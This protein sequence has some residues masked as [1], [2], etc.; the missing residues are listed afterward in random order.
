[1]LDVFIKIYRFGKVVHI[2]VDTN[3]D[4]AAFTRAFKHLFVHTLL[5]RNDGRKHH[6]AGALGQFTH[7]RND[8]VDRLLLY[9]LAAYRTVRNTDTGIEQAEIIVNLGRGAHRRA[10]IARG[11]LLVDGNRRGQALDQIDV[12]LVELSEKHSR[13]GRKRFDEASVS[14]GIK[15]IE[16]KA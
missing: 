6:K 7:S 5:R 11:G 1:M 4:V 2:A 14:L 12:G 9:F 16:G 8:L 13:I 15:G 3:T 10:R